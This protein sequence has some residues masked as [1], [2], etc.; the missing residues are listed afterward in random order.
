MHLRKSKKKRLN[1]LSIL[2]KPFI[3]LKAIIDGNYN[4]MKCR[5]VKYYLNEYLGGKL[6]DEMR[7]EISGH[8]DT[9]Y[10]CRKK[11]AELKLTLQSSGTL[12][13]EIH[14][15]G[16][17]WEG[18]SEFNE[19]DPAINLNNILYSPLRRREDTLFK[20]KLRRRVLRS[21]W[22]AVGAP[23]SAVLAAILISV[24]YFSKTSPAF[25]QVQTLKG[26]PVAGDKIINDSGILPAGGWLKT[27][28][29][30]GA[31]LK[32]GMAGEMDVDPGSELQL[33]ST[34]END[35]KVYLKFGRLYVKIWTPTNLLSLIIPS[36]YVIDK[37]STYTI[38]VDKSGSSSLRV[39]TGSII[40]RSGTDNEIIPAG[41]VCETMKNRNPG[42]P[43]FQNSSAAFKTALSVYDFG[44]RSRADLEKVIQNA[45]KND[46]MSLWYLLKDTSPGGMELVYNKLAE[47]VPPPAGVSLDG[48]K[49]GDNNMLL[50]WWDRLGCGSKSLWDSIK[51]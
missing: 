36:A 27:D 25:W 37:G 32:T 2:I 9:C 44:N 30:S 50:M 39:I 24:F 31:R 16:E 11:A 42:T 7:R 20:I 18:V 22:I 38:E 28:I 5:E 4:K 17:L 26:S 48:I 1:Y 6:I 13:K 45:G 43:Y 3:N 40:I 15:G 35:Y 21:R 51:G 23:L 33:V 10:S 49:K 14:Q 34:K 47:L 46:A 29:H 41:A 8:L 19:N 12:R